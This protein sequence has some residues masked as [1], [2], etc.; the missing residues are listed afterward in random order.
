MFGGVGNESLCSPVSQQLSGRR[1]TQAGRK[2]GRRRV[3]VLAETSRD[4]S[5]VQWLLFHS[6]YRAFGAQGRWGCWRSPYQAAPGGNDA[7]PPPFKLSR[8]HLSDH[9]PAAVFRH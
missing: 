7:S 8:C 9:Y 6:C 5:A 1:G 4:V 2:A 3:D